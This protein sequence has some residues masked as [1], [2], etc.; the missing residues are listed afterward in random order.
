MTIQTNNQLFTDLKVTKI[1]PKGK[2]FYAMTFMAGSRKMVI[3]HPTEGGGQF[4]WYIEGRGSKQTTKSDFWKWIKQYEGDD[5]RKIAGYAKLMEPISLGAIVCNCESCGRG[6]DFRTR[7]YSSKNYQQVLCKKCQGKAATTGSGTDSIY[8]VPLLSIERL[9]EMK[10]YQREAL[11]KQIDKALA[12]HG[13]IES[14]YAYREDV[15][16]LL[17]D[18][19]DEVASASDDQREEPAET[20]GVKAGNEE[21]T[22]KQLK[23]QAKAAGIKGYSKMNKAQLT[24]VLAGASVSSERPF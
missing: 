2:E 23:A 3:G 4:M 21:A 14:L 17:P 13:E 7:E 22:L 9:T 15:Y 10:P 16:K 12:K 11:I 1:T 24:M 20:A 18:Y 5:A 19:A 8:G 6:V